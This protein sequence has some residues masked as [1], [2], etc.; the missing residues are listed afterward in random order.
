MTQLVIPQGTTQ[1]RIEAIAINLENQQE[2]HKAELECVVVP[3]D[4]S[5]TVEG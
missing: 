5:S 4:F 3:T 1:I 2:S